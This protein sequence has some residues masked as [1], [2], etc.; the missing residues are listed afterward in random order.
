V[1]ACAAVEQGSEYALD[2]RCPT[3]TRTGS[4]ITGK[5]MLVM[6]DIGERKFCIPQNEQLDEEPR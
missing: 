1:N 4:D 2:S 5:G 3:E 6:G